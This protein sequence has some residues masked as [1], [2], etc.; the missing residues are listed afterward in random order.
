MAMTVARTD[1]ESM[2]WINRLLNASPHHKSYAAGASKAGFGFYSSRDDIE[3]Q[4][5]GN[6]QPAGSIF[7]QPDKKLFSNI[8]M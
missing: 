6:L 2:S 5:M 3:D 7:G 4:D 8:W 1:L